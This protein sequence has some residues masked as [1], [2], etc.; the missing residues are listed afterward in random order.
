M[1]TIIPLDDETKSSDVTFLY[2]SE[3]SN[4]CQIVLVG[5][6]FTGTGARK[7]FK[8]ITPP[9]FS[10]CK[11]TQSVVDTEHGLVYYVASPQHCSELAV[12]VLLPFQTSLQY[13]AV[14]RTTSTTS[15]TTS[16]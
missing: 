15:P 1:N 9:D 10:I 12:Y 16:S 6:E 2:A 5:L 4:H 8:V 14:S 3:R 13:S 7:T 11:S